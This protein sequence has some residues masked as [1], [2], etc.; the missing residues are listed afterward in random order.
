MLRLMVAYE[1]LLEMLRFTKNK[2]AF[3]DYVFM[4]NLGKDRLKADV[5]LHKA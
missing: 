5:F 3:V 2:L 4:G 1:G